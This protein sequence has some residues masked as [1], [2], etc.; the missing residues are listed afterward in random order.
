MRHVSSYLEILRRHGI[1]MYGLA[2]VAEVELGELE[3]ELAPSAKGVRR[4]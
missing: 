3:L 4:P 2:C 1:C